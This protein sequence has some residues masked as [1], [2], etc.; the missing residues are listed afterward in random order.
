MRRIGLILLALFVL[1]GCSRQ[2]T[3]TPQDIRPGMDIKD[4]QVVTL[5]GYVYYFDRL[6]FEADS[7]SG[8]NSVVEEKIENGSIAYVDVPHVTRIPLALV[9]SVQRRK[10]EMGQTML[11]GAGLVGLGVIMIDLASSDDPT[12]ESQ[13]RGKPPISVPDDN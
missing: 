5:D 9:E 3:V 7:L 8:F 12:Y 2:V 11:Y 13:P 1:I 10:R 4:A 6:V